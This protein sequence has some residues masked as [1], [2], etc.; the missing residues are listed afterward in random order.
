MFL[1]LSNGGTMFFFA[2]VIVL[3]A[4]WSWLFLPE[5]SGMS[6]ESVNAIFELPWWQI[7]R[8]GRKVAERLEE[9]KREEREEKEAVVTVE[10]VEID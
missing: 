8:R 10:R 9:E 3:G 7:G 4:V 5:L 2:A 6:L 1:A